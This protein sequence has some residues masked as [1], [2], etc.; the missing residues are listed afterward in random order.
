[1]SRRFTLEEA[2]GL[3]P[4]IEKTLREAISHKS[5]FEQAEGALQAI[6][7][8]VIMLGGV[9]VDRQAVYQDKL[10]RDQS[11]ELLKAAI[12]KI[13]E[14]GCVIKDLD[15]GLIDFPTMFR[16]EEVY[17][18]WKLGEAGIAFWH[19]TQEGFAG[20]KPIDTDFRDHHRGDAAN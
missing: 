3:L 2:E 8:R 13:Q 4:E 12:E 18:C 15:I 5:E 10:R 9:L 6:N 1:M 17:L 11:G 7:Q 19:G 14:F 16:G 20:R